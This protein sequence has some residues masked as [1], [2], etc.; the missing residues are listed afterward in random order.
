MASCVNYEKYF[1]YE[2]VQKL[3]RDNREYFVVFLEESMKEYDTTSFP[4]T[5]LKSFLHT[6]IVDFNIS[7]LLRQH[8]PVV[9]TNQQQS[10]HTTHRTITFA[11][12][13]LF[14]PAT[15]FGQ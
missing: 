12:S 7:Y 6:H 11:H 15:F 8:H 10:I 1:K 3:Q 4:W 2:S 13:D 5:S 14:Y 9:Q